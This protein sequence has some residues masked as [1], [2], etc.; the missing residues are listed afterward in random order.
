MKQV[1]FL[2]SPEKRDSIVSA[3]LAEYGLRLPIVARF[4]GTN[5]ER[6]LEIVQGLP[7][8]TYVDGLAGGVSAVCERTAPQ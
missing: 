1:F 5:K 2:L 7:G 4:V 6:G 8:V 3:A